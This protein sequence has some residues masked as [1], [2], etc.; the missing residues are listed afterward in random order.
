[1]TESTTRPTR[2]ARHVP[3]WIV[4]T[5][6]VGPPR[7]LLG[8]GRAVRPAATPRRSGACS[9]STPVGRKT[10]KK[11]VAIVGYIEDGPNSSSRP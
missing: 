1:M 11:R 3:R 8:H 10:G 7:R 6:W 2:S 9:G 4:R 5:I